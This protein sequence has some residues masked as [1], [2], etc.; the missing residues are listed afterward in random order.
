MG[1]EENHGD[2]MPGFF[3][4]VKKSWENRITIS[5]SFPKVQP[6]LWRHTSGVSQQLFVVSQVVKAL[7][8]MGKVDSL[9]C[10]STQKLFV[11]RIPKNITQPKSNSK[12]LT[13]N[14]KLQKFHAT[15][16]KMQWT[17]Q[18]VNTPLP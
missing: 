3:R 15:T 1:E 14:G 13:E 7:V 17:V 4:V 12:T 9:T 8:G 5:K 18:L 16:S 6:N 2:N 11:R 10:F